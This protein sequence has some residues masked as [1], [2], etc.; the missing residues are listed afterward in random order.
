MFALIVVIKLSFVR[1][2]TASIND[3]KEPVS[4]TAAANSRPLASTTEYYYYLYLKTFIPSK[5]ICLND[6][7]SRNRQKLKLLQKEASFKNINLELL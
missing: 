6:N 1:L 2:F 7:H 5:N 4:C 3:W